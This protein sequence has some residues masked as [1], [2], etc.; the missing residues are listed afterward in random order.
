MDR[1]LPTQLNNAHKTG[2]ASQ[3]E[4]LNLSKYGEPFSF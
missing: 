4:H 3:K 1:G 2:L